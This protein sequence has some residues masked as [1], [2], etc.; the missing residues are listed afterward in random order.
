MG[1]V[2]DIQHFAVCD[3][4]GKEQEIKKRDLESDNYGRIIPPR[5]WVMKW[6]HGEV[7]YMCFDC[8]R[9]FDHEPGLLARNGWKGHDKAR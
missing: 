5:G 2:Q 6:I 4:C 3:L 8:Q 1:Y 7:A 9:K